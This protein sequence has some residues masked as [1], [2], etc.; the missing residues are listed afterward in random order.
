MIIEKELDDEGQ[1]IEIYTP[2]N[3]EDNKKLAE[4][5]KQGEIDPGKFD[6]AE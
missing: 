4:M 2:E 5:S 6:G 1:I 3:E